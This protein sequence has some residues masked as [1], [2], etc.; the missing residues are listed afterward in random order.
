MEFLVFIII[1]YAVWYTDRQK[2][3]NSEKL[4]LYNNIGE[5]LVL[6][7][8]LYLCKYIVE[9][10][11]HLREEKVRKNEIISTEEILNILSAKGLEKYI[12]GYDFCFCDDYYMS[13]K[14]TDGINL[15]IN[16]FSETANEISQKLQSIWENGIYYFHPLIGFSVDTISTDERFLPPDIIDKIKK[17]YK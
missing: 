14:P 5:I 4:S 10:L 9:I 2:R 3:K 1:F 11:T 13:F 16:E 6:Q 17:I 7:R 15:F 12:N 8:T